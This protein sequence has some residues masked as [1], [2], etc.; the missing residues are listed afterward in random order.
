MPEVKFSL[1]VCG[2]EINATMQLPSEPVRPVDLFPIF[3]GLSNAIVGA[4]SVDQK[5]SCRAGCGACCRQVVPISETEVLYLADVIS[6]MPM[7]HRLE[8]VKRFDLAVERIRDAG[9][10]DKL[11][12]EAMSTTEERHRI[13]DQYFD[14][15][16]ACPFLEDES[17]SIHPHRPL[18][19]REYLVTSP[20]SEC[21]HPTA[22]TIEMVE[23]PKKLSYIL[24]RFG[25]AVGKAPV[26]FIPMTLMFEQENLQ[27][28]RLP[29]P[30]LFQN[31]FA[32]VTGPM[33]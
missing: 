6:N 14:L 31:F 23:M 8:I 28:P 16:I 1:K 20:A 10:A 7:E 25:D 29:G 26:K 33:D 30:E 5:V 15:N 9:L 19:C 24:Y 17:C 3:A 21:S 32:A 18:A 2:H 12:L 4:A 13:A 22:E 27:Q 11:T